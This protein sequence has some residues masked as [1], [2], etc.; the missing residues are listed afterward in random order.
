MSDNISN[1]NM[2]IN[3]LS[4]SKET[5][6]M[7]KAIKE[8]SFTGLIKDNQYAVTGSCGYVNL[9]NYFEIENVETGHKLFVDSDCILD[10]GIA[11]HDAKGWVLSKTKAKK[12]L[13]EKLH[14]YQLAVCLNLLADLAST[15]TDEMLISALNYYTNRNCFTP[16]Q[17][18]LVFEV[19][20]ENKIV[21]NV[22]WFKISLHKD[23]HL[24]QISSLGARIEYILP[25]LTNAQLITVQ[26][27]AGLVQL[28]Y[29]NAYISQKPHLMPDSSEISLEL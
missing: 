14:D 12:L 11:V 6:N 27:N 21:Y 28:E 22:K 19:L 9:R 8:W 4:F 1:R 7:K 17:A 24:A 10:F 13:S 2:Q 26:Q 29:I 25:A 15:K 20:A 3:L 23:I 18:A 5:R 16:K